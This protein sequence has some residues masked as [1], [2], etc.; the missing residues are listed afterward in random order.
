MRILSRY[1]LKEFLTP[2]FYCFTAFASLHLVFELFGEFDKILQA[3]PPASFILR[4]IGGFLAKDF[5]WL[6]TPSLLLGG[7][8]AMWQLARHGEITAMRAG[9]IGFSAITAPMLASA[10]VFSTVAF[11]SSEFY[12]PRAI[13]VADNIKNNDFK[14]DEDADMYNVPYNNVAKRRDW[15][16]GRFM[17]EENLFHDVKITWT[18]HDGYKER[19]LT[20]PR[21]LY[22]GNAWW[23]L[24]A[25]MESFGVD[26]QQNRAGTLLWER[27][28]VVMPELEEIPRDFLIESTQQGVNPSMEVLT[29]GDMAR[30]LRTR[31]G[32]AENQ[33]RI[34]IYEI[35]NRC[36]SPLACVFITLFAIPAGVATGRQSVFSGVVMAIVLFIGYYALT[37]FSGVQAKAGTIPVWLG[38]LLPN[39]AIFSIGL[40]IFHRQR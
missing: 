38:V 34:L 5:Q 33:R 16:I 24:D 14:S 40:W 1:V 11:L 13:M 28:L 26:A 9:G 3:K 22:Q 10:V 25:A 30:Y 32:L 2:V 18:D 12:A 35:F 7:L 8:Y 4:Y 36:V 37:L 6:I 29:I 19:V 15:Q 39:I 17:P 23:F 21:A 27:G 20:A 31:T